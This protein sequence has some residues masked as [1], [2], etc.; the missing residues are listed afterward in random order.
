MLEP[1]MIAELENNSVVVRPLETHDS[2]K[3]ES[4]RVISLEHWDRVAVL[5]SHYEREV[6]ITK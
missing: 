2:A 3:R 1:A 4:A 5:I 6:Q